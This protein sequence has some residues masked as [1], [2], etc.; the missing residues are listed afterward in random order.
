MP[1]GNTIE[2]RIDL[3]GLRIVDAQP[4][5]DLDRLIELRAVISLECLDRFRNRHRVFFF[6]FR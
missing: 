4:D 5:R 6:L 3:L 2:P 1:C